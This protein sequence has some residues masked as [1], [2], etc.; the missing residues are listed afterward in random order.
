MKEPTAKHSNE[1]TAGPSKE[2]GL[3]A[4]DS[5]VEMPVSFFVISESIRF[6]SEIN[7]FIYMVLLTRIYSIGLPFENLIV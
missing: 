3:E 7:Y 4:D 6:V 2:T 1:L 5:D